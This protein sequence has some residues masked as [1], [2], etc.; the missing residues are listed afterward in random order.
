LELLFQQAFK[1]VVG[2]TRAANA[3]PQGNARA[4]YLS[5]PGYARV[6]DEL[7]QRVVGLI[8]NVFQA[9]EIKGDIKK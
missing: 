3:F 8:G 4:L 6:M 7:S 1:N 5:Y 9:K 2:A